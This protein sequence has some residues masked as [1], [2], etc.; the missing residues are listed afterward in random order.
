MGKVRRRCALEGFEQA[1][2]G[3][4]SGSSPPPKLLCGE[5]EGGVDRAASGPAAA[6]LRDTFA[7]AAGVEGR[8]AWDHQLDQ[9]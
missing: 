1:L 7:T 6:R 9:P 2:N 5:Q 4:Q 3:E 8:G